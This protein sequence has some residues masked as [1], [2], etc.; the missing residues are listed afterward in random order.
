MDGGV[1]CI[2]R[3][4][5]SARRLGPGS[6]RQG[7]SAGAGGCTTLRQN[8][9]G[10]TV[11]D[12]GEVVYAWHPW[13]GR[14]VRLHEVITRASGVVLRCSLAGEGVMRSQEIP[15]WMLDQA[16]CRK[17]RCVPHPVAE[18]GAL[19]ALRALL[20]EVVATRVAAEKSPSPAVAS[21]DQD[22]GERHG[23][24]PPP[25]GPDTESAARPPRPAAI[26]G[27]QRD[28]GLEL[29][30]IGYTAHADRLDDAL[31]GPACRRRGARST[32]QRR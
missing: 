15:A 11:V 4:W 20:L 17:M 30:A 2:T 19:A 7:R 27:A 25:P 23:A 6:R 32:E 18:L 29:V 13:A 9:H 24:T 21:P 31:A 26:I 1:R 16:V 8:T 12:D 14:A 5:P 22:R 3:P 10:T 28:A